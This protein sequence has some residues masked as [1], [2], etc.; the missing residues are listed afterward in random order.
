MTPSDILQ[1]MA[2]TGGV[3]AAALLDGRGHVIETAGND[4]IDLS[5]VGRAAEAL[6]ASGDALAEFLS[7][8]RPQQVMVDYESGPVLLATLGAGRDAPL[9]LLLLDAFE[10]L[11]RARFHLR[12]SLAALA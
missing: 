2:T 3:R 7:G 11:G 10:S 4:E 1:D 12:R 5:F 6:I 9:I 8:T